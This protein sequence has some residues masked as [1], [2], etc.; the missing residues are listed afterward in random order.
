MKMQPK[1]MVSGGENRRFMQVFPPQ[2]GFFAVFALPKPDV[3]AEL[4]ACDT[5]F[6]TTVDGPYRGRERRLRPPDGGA[7]R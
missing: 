3:P 7:Q 1:N 2:A 5:M 4:V 6:Q